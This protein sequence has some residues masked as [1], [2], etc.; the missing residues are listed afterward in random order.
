MFRDVTPVGHIGLKTDWMDYTERCWKKIP[1]RV[2][3]VECYDSS[4][5]GFLEIL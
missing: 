1:L 4:T 2:N 3:P 5:K